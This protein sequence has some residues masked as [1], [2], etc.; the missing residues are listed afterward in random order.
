MKWLLTGLCVIAIAT[1]PVAA[2]AN[3][4][5]EAE[6]ADRI[7]I[8]YIPEHLQHRVPGHQHKHQA[9]PKSP[10]EGASELT[11]PELQVEKSRSGIIAS[12][13]FM[14]LGVGMA[15]IGGAIGAKADD[16]G[17]AFGAISLVGVGA[18]FLVGGSIGIGISSHRKR[19]AET[20]L[21]KLRH[22]RETPQ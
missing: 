9:A 17:A 15:A 2:S 7:V 21:R 20:E 3:V 18:I 10:S 4:E 8:A 12:S 16:Y 22:V 11:G 1:T 19:E 6:S 5:G 13:I 14:G